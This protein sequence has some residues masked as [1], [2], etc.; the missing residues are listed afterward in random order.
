[1]STIAPKRVVTPADLLAMPDAAFYE[2]VDGELVERNVSALSSRVEGIIFSLLNVHCQAPNAGITWP[3]S[4]G[5]RFYPN[6]PDK[7]RR[8]DVTFVRRDRFSPEYYRD[9]FLTFRPDLVVEV[10]SPNDNATEVDE[11]IEEYLAAGIPLVW[12]VNPQTRLVQA[13][14]KDG[15]ASRLHPSD[16]LT[17]ED[18]LPGF[19]CRVAELFP[20]V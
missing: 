14:R 7:V 10:I 19:H 9:G 18:V 3:S 12:E 17:G 1:M 6:D 4:L 13:H 2:L 11:K 8:P 20:D 5:C 15:S 16:E